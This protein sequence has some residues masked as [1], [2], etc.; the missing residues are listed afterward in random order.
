MEDLEGRNCSPLPFLH[1]W[2]KFPG[3][4]SSI[5]IIVF[6]PDATLIAT[7]D[8]NGMLSVSRNYRHGYPPSC[9]HGPSDMASGPC[10]GGDSEILPS[11]QNS[12]IM[13]G[14]STTAHPLRRLRQWL[15][16]YGSFNEYRGT[17]ALHSA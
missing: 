7:G 3:D 8:D 6:S 16:V 9:P 5:G 14:S 11:V 10:V 13:L 15:P 2:R 17:I 4:G 12:G 1:G